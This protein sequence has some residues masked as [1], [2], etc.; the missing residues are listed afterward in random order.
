MSILDMFSEVY[1]FLNHSFNCPIWT[2]Q[3][4]K[5]FNDATGNIL[6]MVQVFINL[7]HILMSL[8]TMK[9]L[10]M[11]DLATLRALGFQASIIQEFVDKGES[12]LGSN[13][14]ATPSS[15]GKANK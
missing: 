4:M 9:V 14:K 15:V 12:L 10:K 8:S 7:L 13:S 2:M 5:K 6:L 1:Q 11:S 3:G